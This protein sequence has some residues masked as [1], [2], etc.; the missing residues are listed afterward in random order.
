MFDDEPAIVENEHIRQLTPV[1][2]AMS[3]PTGTTVSGRPIAAYTLA[4]N[5]AFAPPDARDVLREPLSRAP[6]I[7]L[8]RYR[9]NVWGYHALNLLVHLAVALT[10][11]GVVRRTLLSESLRAR[12]ESQAT[13][14]PFVVALLWVV[15]PLT[16]AS[17]TYVIQRVESLMSLFYLLTVYCA[18]RAWDPR[19]GGGAW[20]AA[21]V[22]ACILG[23]GTKETM[24]ATA[25][26]TRRPTAI[27]K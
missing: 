5:Y 16:T 6:W 25:D 3:A 19:A 18:I 27:R 8:S 22:A 14:L 17:V 1:S 7:E 11:F 24:I 13:N 2:R 10:L 20:M 26:K 9:S 12:Y 23:M 21:S 4:I 15:H